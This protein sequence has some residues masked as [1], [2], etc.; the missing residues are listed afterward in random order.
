MFVEKDTNFDAL[1]FVVG[2]FLIAFLSICIV[3]LGKSA[4]FDACLTAFPQI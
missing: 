1:T 4:R 2:T 3:L